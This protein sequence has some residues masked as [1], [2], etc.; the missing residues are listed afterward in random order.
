MSNYKNNFIENGFD[1]FE[2]EQAAK[3]EG[4]KVT[5]RAK[6]GQGG[7]LFGA[8]TLG[9][10]ADALKEQFGFEVDKR[11]LS[12]S[13]EMKNAGDYNAEAKLYSGISAKFTVSVVAENG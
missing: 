5:V 13:S 7:K 3:L 12:V 11:K 10:V 9:N 6:G 1:L 2:K 8:V 4:K